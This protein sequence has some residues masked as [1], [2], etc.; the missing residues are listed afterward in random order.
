MDNSI[1]T[2]QLK[3]LKKLIYQAKIKYEKAQQAENKIFEFLE[4]IGIEYLSEIPC[5]A[6]NADNLEEGISCYLNYGE[7]SIKDIIDTI[8]N[9]PNK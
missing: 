1:T 8:K 7:W 3:E 6:D 2:A 4:Q 5:N 9:I